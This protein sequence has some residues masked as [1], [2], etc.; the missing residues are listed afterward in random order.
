MPLGQPAP[1]SPI[2]L[3]HRTSGPPAVAVRWQRA[4]RA[5]TLPRIED[6]PPCVNLPEVAKLVDE[7]VAR[8]LA[9]VVVVVVVGAFRGGAGSHC[10]VLIRHRNNQSNPISQ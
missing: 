7:V 6:C 3:P 2:M 4:M 5:A 8:G 9:V 10:T 1:I